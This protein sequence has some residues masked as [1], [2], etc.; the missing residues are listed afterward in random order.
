VPALKAPFLET[1]PPAGQTGVQSPE[2][3]PFND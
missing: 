1:G 3:G 2:N